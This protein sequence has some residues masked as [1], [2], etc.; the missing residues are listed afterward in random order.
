MHRYRDTVIQV[1]RY[2]DKGTAMQWL[3]IWRYRY[4]F[5]YIYTQTDY[6]DRYRYRYRCKYR[7]SLDIDIDT[8]MNIY[9]LT[10]SSMY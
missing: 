6:R 9:W 7:Y 2:T 1:W 4:R 10:S 8:H 5:I 3:K